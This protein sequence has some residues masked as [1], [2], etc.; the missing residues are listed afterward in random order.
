MILMTKKNNILKKASLSAVTLGML[1]GTLYLGHTVHADTINTNNNLQSEDIKVNSADE[2]VTQVHNVTETIN[3]V[4][5][6]GSQAAP[7]KTATRSFSRVDI[8]NKATGM[9]VNPGGGWNARSQTFD[10]VTSPA[11]SGYKADI[12]KISSQTVNPDSQN[13]TF[14]VTYDPL[15]NTTGAAN[16]VTENTVMSKDNLNKNTLNTKPV[17]TTSEAGS[18]VQ[19]TKSVVNNM[20]VKTNSVTKNKESQLPQ[21]GVKESGQLLAS[22]MG[23]VIALIGTLGI[24]KKVTEKL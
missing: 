22:I 12:D 8:E 1:I 18:K 9:I 4:Y 7:T 11:I 10:A 6:D 23:M 17:I 3:Y 21:T 5:E 19:S 15:V 2:D 14:T 24:T 20:A 16:K 13:L